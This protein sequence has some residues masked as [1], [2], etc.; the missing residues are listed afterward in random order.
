MTADTLLA[1][2]ESRSFKQN[3]GIRTAD[4]LSAAFL[5]LA[6]LEGANLLR[7]H[8]LLTNPAFRETAPRGAR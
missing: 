3:W 4:V 8:P 7:P 1:T 5:T 6:R 2:F